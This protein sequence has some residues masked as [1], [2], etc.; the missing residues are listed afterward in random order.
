MRV[1]KHVVPVRTLRDWKLQMKK[2][3]CA[4]HLI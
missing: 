1:L 2:N 4:M 3:T